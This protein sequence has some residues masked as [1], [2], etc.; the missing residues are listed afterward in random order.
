MGFIKFTWHSADSWAT[1]GK[2][3]NI[4]NSASLRAHDYHEDWGLVMA[5]DGFIEYSL[6]GRNF[7]HV[8]FPGIRSLNVSNKFVNNCKA[9]G[10]LDLTD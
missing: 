7:Y 9:K 4:S 6:D 5:A 3:V 2:L 1:S 8:E 10:R